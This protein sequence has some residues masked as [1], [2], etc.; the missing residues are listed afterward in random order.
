MRW[1]IV[2]L[3][4]VTISGCGSDDDG[5]E[6]TAV[7]APSTTA[8]SKPP[9]KPTSSLRF[10]AA[11]SAQHRWTQKRYSTKAGTVE[12]R[13]AN[14]SDT[15][16]NVAIEKSKK[17]CEQRGHKWL[18][19]SPTIGGGETTKVVVDLKPGSYWA[20]CNI[21]S[22]WQGGMVSRLVVVD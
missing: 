3:V 8:E 18:A 19:T 21:G 6:G 7:T 10:V 15:V 5:D 11:P 22:H 20:Y 13:L 14:A 9:P 17:C 12:V 1:W 4:A 16:H 2:P